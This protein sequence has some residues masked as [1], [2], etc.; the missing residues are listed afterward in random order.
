M[1]NPRLEI[2]KYGLRRL[3]SIARFIQFGGPGYEAL[4][5]TRRWQFPSG[6]DLNETKEFLVH[7]IVSSGAFEQVERNFQ[8]SWERLLVALVTSKETVAGTCRLLG[9]DSVARG[10][11]NEP[12]KN[13]LAIVQRVVNK[14]SIIYQFPGDHYHPVSRKRMNDIRLNALFKK[15]LFGKDPMT[16]ARN[17]ES[18]RDA[19]TDPYIRG[20]FWSQYVPGTGLFKVSVSNL[21]QVTECDDYCSICMDEF[22]FTYPGI[23]LSPCLH[24][25]HPKCIQHLIVN[26]ISGQVLC[27]LC[28]QEVRDILAQLP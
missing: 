12:T 28:R 1:C 3:K 22:S 24:V 27:P 19:L 23:H 20:I 21:E 2:G 10:V 5:E 17:V 7:Q 9:L 4:F 6:E 13:V 26:R 8:Y 11:I 18:F 16:V 15:D 14:L 25:F